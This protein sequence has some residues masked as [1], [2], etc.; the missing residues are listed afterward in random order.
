MPGHTVRHMQYVTALCVR[1]RLILRFHRHHDANVHGIASPGVR[2]LY[3]RIY[4]ILG[5]RTRMMMMMM[6][7]M[8][9]TT[10]LQGIKN[11]VNKKVSCLTQM[12]QIHICDGPS[13]SH[14]DHGGPDPLPPC[15]RR[16]LPPTN[17]D[18]GVADAETTLVT[19]A[20]EAML[21][22]RHII[23]L[24]DRHSIRAIVAGTREVR[25]SVR[26]MEAVLSQ[27]S[28]SAF[29]RALPQVVRVGRVTQQRPTGAAS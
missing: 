11:Y 21:I 20:D 29:A 1:V 24:V 8:M 19:G 25:C 26:R 18:G 4:R 15:R 23:V 28:G 3:W 27:C 16:L 10:G 14:R 13:G 7:I 9:T 22:G 6:T 12:T 2:H 5:L 17:I